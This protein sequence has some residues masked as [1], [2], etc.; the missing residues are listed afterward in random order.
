MTEQTAARQVER[1]LRRE[2]D[3]DQLRWI[4]QARTL[5]AALDLL[6]QPVVLLLPGEPMRVWHANATARHRLGIHPELRIRDG[7]LHVAPACAQALGQAIARARERGPDHPQQLLLSSPTAPAT[8]HVQLLDFGATRDLP[9]ST[10]F[11]LELREPVSAEQGLRQLCAEFRLTR[12]EAEAALGLYA[13]GSIGQLA[14][15][16]G[17]SVHTIRTQLKAAMQKT[18]TH[19][20]AGLVALVARR[21]RA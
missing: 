7:L 5:A 4:A 11:M 2:R 13:M 20:Q 1:R 16:T 21:S 3:P 8:I 14:R 18:E 15:C 9:V 6:A 17:K 10:V 19:T 12:K